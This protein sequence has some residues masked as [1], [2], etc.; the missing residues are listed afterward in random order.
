MMILETFAVCRHLHH[1]KDY[2]G[3]GVDG[4]KQS[5]VQCR[6]Y[7]PIQSMM[8]QSTS[9]SLQLVLRMTAAC[10]SNEKP[11]TSF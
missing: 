8:R 7:G 1:Q 5:T 11:C 2:E 9:L 10:F 6:K 3:S 4:H